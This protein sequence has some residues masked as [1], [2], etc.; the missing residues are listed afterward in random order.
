MADIVGNDLFDEDWMQDLD[1]DLDG[2]AIDLG[3]TDGLPEDGERYTT[4]KVY[5]NIAKP[6]MYEHAIDLARDVDLADGARTFAFVSGNFVFG[7]FIEALCDIRKIYLRTISVQTL[8]MSAENID[9]L[10]NIK[11]ICPDLEKMDIVLSDYF[12]SHERS[13]LVRYLYEELDNDDK[14]DVAFASIHTKICTIETMHGNKIV[15]DG[16][17]NMRSS[18][19]VEQMRIEIDPGLFDFIEGF[20]NRIME[21]YGVINHDVT[22][23]KSLRGGKI[24]QAAARGSKATMK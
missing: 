10:R 21:A 5:G 18:R 20:K 9:S 17:A 12:Y 24:W 3:K 7:D 13:G 11:I 23:N 22:R 14:L 4:P 15:I 2:F 19:N 16:S 1:F 6:V 8:S